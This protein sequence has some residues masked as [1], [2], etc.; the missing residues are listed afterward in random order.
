MSHF[1]DIQRK[2]SEICNNILN[3]FGVS[4]SEEDIEKAHKDGD[5]HPNGKWVWASSAA[6]GKGDWRTLNGRTHKKHQASGG[7]GSSVSSSSGN[8]AGGSGNSN[9]GV[10]AGKKSAAVTKK[11]AVTSTTTAKLTSQKLND[12]ADGS[13]IIIKNGQTG[14]SHIELTKENGQW[15]YKDTRRAKQ[16]TTND[17][18]LRYFNTPVRDNREPYMIIMLRVYV[19]SPRHRA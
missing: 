17:N 8:S 7:A 1:D 4:M 3:G 12:L 10:T 9:G 2:R 11:T 19:S 13:S 5:L 6:G 15:Y 18:V 16:K 14:N